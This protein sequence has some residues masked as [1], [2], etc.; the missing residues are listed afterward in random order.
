MDNP[1]MIGSIQ[2]VPGVD[3]VR[4]LSSLGLA[5]YLAPAGS[6]SYADPSVLVNLGT[7]S[8]VPLTYTSA[9]LFELTG[10]LPDT[11]NTFSTEMNS[12]VAGPATPTAAGNVAATPATATAIVAATDTGLTPAGTTTVG[13]AA[14]AAA[15]IRA[16]NATSVATS[17]AVT[18]KTNGTAADAS[19]LASN[20]IQDNAAQ[21]LDNIAS[22]PAYANIATSLYLNSAIFRAQHLSDVVLPNITRGIQPVTAAHAVYRV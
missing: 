1:Y 14:A 4:A 8:P 9:G 11:T 22:N 6:T 2:A 15:D 20:F 21:A 13:P 7:L 16:G 19:A 5:S 18:A 3:T 12:I 10:I 17:T